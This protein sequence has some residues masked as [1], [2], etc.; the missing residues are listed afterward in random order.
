MKETLKKWFQKWWNSDYEVLE[1]PDGYSCTSWIIVKTIAITALLIWLFAF[2]KDYNIVFDR[3]DLIVCIFAI[4]CVAAFVYVYVQINKSIAERKV[5]TYRNARL[6]IRLSQ[7]I[8]GGSVMIVPL[9]VIS[10]HLWVVLLLLFNS[11]GAMALNSAG[12]M[13]HKGIKMQEEQDLTI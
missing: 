12:W 1:E 3:K 7:I 8:G 9:A 2:I 4:P 6:L 5:F 13:I 11:M 10:D